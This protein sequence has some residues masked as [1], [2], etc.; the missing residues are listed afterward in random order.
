MLGQAAGVVPSR[1]MM[2]A[3]LKRR[4]RDGSTDHLEHGAEVTHDELVREANDAAA[5]SLE[6]VGAAQIS[7]PQLSMV[8][9]I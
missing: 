2:S 3:L 6:L 9:S 7:A 1:V 4:S 8:T 5:E